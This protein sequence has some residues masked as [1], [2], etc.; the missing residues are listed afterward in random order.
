MREQCPADLHP[1]MPQVISSATEVRNVPI[2]NGDDE[3]VET[4]CAILLVFESAI[5]KSALAVDKNRVSQ[6]M[7]GLSLVQSGLAGAAQYR[8]F[9][10]V[11]REQ[12]PFNAAEL[13]K[14]VVELVLAASSEWF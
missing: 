8:L 3:Q 14:G 2:C 7:T 6:S 5:Q 13:T 12:R 1:G 10:P 11:Q 9:Q 4:G